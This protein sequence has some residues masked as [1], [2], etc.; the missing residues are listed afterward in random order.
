MFAFSLYLEFTFFEQKM[1][2]KAG[3]MAQWVK[4]LANL[5]FIHIL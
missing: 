2:S 5:A 3:K 1:N 4:M